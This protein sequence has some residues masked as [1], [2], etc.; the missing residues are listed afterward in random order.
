MQAFLSWSLH[1]FVHSLTRISLISLDFVPVDEFVSSGNRGR[2]VEIRRIL[3]RM[4]ALVFAY[5]RRHDGSV[6]DAARR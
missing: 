3:D 4:G 1:V 2:Y 5:G 6:L